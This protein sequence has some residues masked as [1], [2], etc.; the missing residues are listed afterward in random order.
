M[1]LFREGK[2]QTKGAFPI[3]S[4]QLELNHTEKSGNQYR[5][6]GSEYSYQKVKGAGVFTHQF[7]S[8]IG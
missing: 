6:H 5:I 7:L 8:H 2:E 4:E 1:K 3:H